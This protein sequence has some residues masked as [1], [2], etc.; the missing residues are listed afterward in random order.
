MKLNI[1]LMALLISSTIEGQNY[2]VALIPDSLKMDANVVKRFEE[3]RVIIRSPSKAIVKHKYALTILTEEGRRNSYYY[4]FYSKLR[5][6]SDISGTMY[7]AAGKPVKTIKKKDISD[8]SHDDDM[9]LMTDS[10]VKSYNFYSN[11]LPY[12]VEFE[13]EIEYDCLFYLPKWT[14]QSGPGYA[15]QSSSLIVE[16]PTDY[17]FRFKQILYE[18]KPLITNTSKVNNYQWQVKNIAAI[19]EEP[20]QPEWDE[21]LTSVMLAPTKFE[22]GGYAGDMTSW[23][24]FGKYVSSLMVGRDVLPENVKADVHR[25]T[26]Q[27]TN[28]QQKIEALY[29]YLQKNTRYISIQL[30][31]GGLQP[32]PAKDVAVKKYGDCKALSN[33]MVSMFKEVGIKANHVLINAGEGEKGLD[34]DFPASYFNHMIMC[35]PDAKDTLWLECTDQFRSAGFMGSSTGNRQALLLDDNGGYVVSTP[36]YTK[37]EN[38]QTRKVMAIVTE[39]GNVAVNINT[40]FSGQQQE[41]QHS[42]MHTATEEQRKKYLNRV[43]QIPTYKI[44][45][46]TYTE[47]KGKVPIVDEFI[48][49]TASNYATSSGKRLFVT[50]NMFNQGGGRLSVD[51]PRKQAI[52]FNYPYRDVD[53]IV[54]QV[55]KGYK[56][57]AIPKDVAFKNKFGLYSISFA[58]SDDTINVVRIAEGNAGLFP[59]SDY[60][61]LARFYEDKYKADRSR[62]VLVKSE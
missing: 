12:T 50:P 44:E 43:L 33:Y 35:V 18:G 39:D 60:V 58:V 54:I 53:T 61:E 15:V 28:R 30:G 52:Q 45:Q 21:V 8:V 25:L 22:Y 48:K 36:H 41:L 17:T 46:S 14:P 47:Q 56:P 59:P 23:V 6:L 13:D 5:S 34:E 49:L 51:K 32:F 37:T 62:I 3:L 40:R 7:D 38:L 1:F 9:S 16:A 11:T 42:L 26:D 2:N 27:L 10:R 19:T 31:I 4:N 24:G 29:D 57:E 20:Y 55:P